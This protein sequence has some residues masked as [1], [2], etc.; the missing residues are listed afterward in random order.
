MPDQLG[1]VYAMRAA[2]MSYE[3]V[4]EVLGV[5]I[6]TVKSR[7]HRMLERLREEMSL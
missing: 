3:G 1:E 5:P 4:A 7:V 6:G 2:G